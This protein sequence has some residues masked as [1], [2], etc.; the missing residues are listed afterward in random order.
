MHAGKT[1]L[2]QVEVDFFLGPPS[3]G[4]SLVTAGIGLSAPCTV[5]NS[6]APWPFARL[7]GRESLRDLEACLGARTHKLHHSGFR[8]LVRGTTLADANE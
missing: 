5:A 1:L 2:A 6:A 3:L 4:S 8:A 7:T